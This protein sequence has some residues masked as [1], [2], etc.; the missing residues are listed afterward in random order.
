MSNVG[1]NKAMFTWINKQ[2]VRS[3]EGFEVQFTGRLTTE[4][5]EGSRHLEVKVEDAGN[6]MIDFNPKAFERWANSPVRNDPVEQ[7]RMLKNFMA[8]LEFQ[9]L[10]GM[11]YERPGT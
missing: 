6:G 2:G 5:R 3:S 1:P 10:K 4:Y 8:A 11:P 7:T 9:G